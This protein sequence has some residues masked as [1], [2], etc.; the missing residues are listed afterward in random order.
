MVWSG[1]VFVF[2]FLF[3]GLVLL[4]FLA[5]S[6]LFMGLLRLLGLIL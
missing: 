4:C 5:F 6:S 1:A 2:V 3:L